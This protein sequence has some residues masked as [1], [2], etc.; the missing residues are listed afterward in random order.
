MLKIF[1]AVLH[2]RIY[3]FLKLCLCVEEISQF[4]VCW[5]QALFLLGNTFARFR[6]FSFRY[7][8]IP[9]IGASEMQDKLRMATRL[10]PSSLYRWQKK[11]SCFFACLSTLSFSHT[12]FFPFK[13]FFVRRKNSLISSKQFSYGIKMVSVIC[14]F[15]SHSRVFSPFF[16]KKINRRILV[17]FCDNEHN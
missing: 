1:C 10:L 3:R 14:Y 2:R 15:W 4:S 17:R 9:W 8:C 12:I 5:K 13:R 11:C 16:E 6:D 7:V